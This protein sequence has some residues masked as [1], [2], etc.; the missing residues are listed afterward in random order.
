MYGCDLSKY[1]Y[2]YL[3]LFPE[4]MADMEDWVFGGL[5]KD[6]VVISNTFRFRKRE[7]F[8][9]VKTNKGK[10]RIFLYK[11]ILDD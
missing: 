3:Y 6:A 11:R 8:Q 7:P 9:V 10:E 1:D 4:Q 2:I 5:K